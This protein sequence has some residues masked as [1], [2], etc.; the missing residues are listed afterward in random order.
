MSSSRGVSAPLAHSTTARARCRC[1]LLLRR[2]R[3]PRSSGPGHLISTLPHVAVGPDFAATGGFGHRESRWRASED[4]APNSH[5]NPMQKPQCWQG[6]A[7]IVGLGQDRDRRGLGMEAQLAR[8]PLEQHARRLHRQRGQRIGPRARRV[9]RPR[10]PGNAQ[11]PVG[12]RVVGLEV[13][14]G[15]RPVGEARPL[16]GRGGSLR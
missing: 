10:R 3:R 2:S 14:I 1:S 4:L 5:P 12:L 16:I 7:A 6:S 13:G 11:L 15:D 9:E 8:A